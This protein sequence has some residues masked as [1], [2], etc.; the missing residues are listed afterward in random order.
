MKMKRLIKASM[1]LMV[2]ALLAA[3]ANEDIAQQ[4]NE[5][6]NEAPKGGVVFATNDTKISAKRRFIDDEAFADA[7]TRTDIKHT[8][9]NGGDA[10]WTSDDFIWVKKQ[11]GT[12]A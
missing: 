1:L 11:D 7:K 10:Y 9:N 12:W 8:P 6:K 2:A 3:C 4:D 5:K